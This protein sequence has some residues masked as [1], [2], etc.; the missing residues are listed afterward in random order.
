MSLDRVTRRR[1]NGNWIELIWKSLPDGRRMIIGRDVTELKEHEQELAIARSIQALMEIRQNVRPGRL[2][3]QNKEKLKAEIGH[4][5]NISGRS[6]SRY[7][8]VLQTPAAV[9]RAFDRGEVSL[10]SAGKIALLT[11]DDQ[12]TIVRRITAGEQASRVVAEFITKRFRD[13]G[14]VDRPFRRLA[15]LLKRDLTPI[16]GRAGEINIDEI[17][18]RTWRISKSS[19]RP[20]RGSSPKHN[21]RDVEHSQR[22]KRTCVTPKADFAR[23]PP[24]GRTP[25]PAARIRIWPKTLF[26]RQPSGGVSHSGC[27]DHLDTAV[28]RAGGDLWTL[29]VASDQYESGLSFQAP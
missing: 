24:G 9:Q 23:I 12:A 2:G 19:D 18:A 14:T 7:L 1:P 20:G 16:A 5:L 15:K 13:R 6:V 26:A 4:L 22:P 28:V 3:W 17:L 8:L 21:G 25:C 29:V 27:G 10:V 11:P